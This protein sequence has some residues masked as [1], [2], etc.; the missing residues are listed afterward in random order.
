LAA[1]SEGEFV[2]AAVKLAS[3]REHLSHLHESL[4]DRM[5]ASPLC[6]AEGFGKRFASAVRAAW[7]QACI[8]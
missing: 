7:T 5:E 2:A 6:D 8:W 1:P 4:R 3:D